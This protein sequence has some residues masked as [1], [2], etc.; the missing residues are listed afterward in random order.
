M[1]ILGIGRHQQ[2]AGNSTPCVKRHH[3]FVPQPGGCIRPLA[4]CRSRPHRGHVHKRAHFLPLG[5][6]L[7][8]HFAALLVPRRSITVRSQHITRTV[9][10]RK[11][12]LIWVLP[13]FLEKAGPVN[14]VPCRQL[15]F[16]LRLQAGAKPLRPSHQV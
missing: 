3:V 9:Q 6:R 1:D 7:P 11:A 8:H 5:Q 14:R 2:N 16:N 12:R 15:L 13:Q 10:H 4:A